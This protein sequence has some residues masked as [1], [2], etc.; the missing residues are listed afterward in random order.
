MKTVYVGLFMS[1]ILITSIGCISAVDVKVNNDKMNVGAV[2]D[3]GVAAHKIPINYGDALLHD[4][5]SRD[6]DKHPFSDNDSIIPNGSNEIHK[7]SVQ[8]GSDIVDNKSVPDDSDGVKNNNIPNSTSENESS[9]PFGHN[10]S[11]DPDCAEIND[12]AVFDV[13][14][15]F[16]NNHDPKRY[17]FVDN[18]SNRK[19][20]KD[21]NIGFKDVGISNSNLCINDIKFRNPDLDIIDLNMD[22]SGIMIKDINIFDSFLDLEDLDVNI[23]N[24]KFKGPRCVF[25]KL[26]ITNYT[27]SRI[28]DYIE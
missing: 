8:N 27:D 10:G 18:G 20:H 11:I 1:L 15:I 19:C 23:T 26:G 12:D 13:D 24:S 7:D 4:G 6:N 21:F 2:V 14:V 17:M 5:F 16:D 9:N 22:S 3:D 28:P 25:F